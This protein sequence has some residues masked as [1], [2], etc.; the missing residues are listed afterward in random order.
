MKEFRIVYTSSALSETST[1]YITTINCNFLQKL[2]AFQSTTWHWRNL[3]NFMLHHNYLSKFESFYRKKKLI[4]IW[5][6]LEEVIR[7]V[8][9]G[10]PRRLHS[11]DKFSSAIKKH[12][13]EQI[14]S[15][16][17]AWEWRDDYEEELPPLCCR[18]RRRHHS[19]HIIFG[20]YHQDRYVVRSVR[21]LLCTVP[22]G[23]LFW[24]WFRFFQKIVCVIV[25][26]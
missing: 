5:N 21:N 26:D 19:L 7:W 8:E 15:Q 1:I 14:I 24:E 18:Y 11:L 17:V 25:D 3:L 13:D 6:W 2:M 23:S 4:W 9:Y 20:D 16:V 10:L 12:L 22:L